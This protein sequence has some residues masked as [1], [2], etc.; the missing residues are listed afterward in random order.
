MMLSLPKGTGEKRGTGD[1]RVFQSFGV[2]GQGP[3]LGWVQNLR[4]QRQT[5]TQ[6]CGKQNQSPGPGRVGAGSSP[7]ATCPRQCSLPGFAAD[8]P[9]A[10]PTP[11]KNRQCACAP[12]HTLHTDLGRVEGPRPQDVT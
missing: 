11:R 6:G 3:G 8:V 5:P 2:D 12:A 10:Q 1:L 7:A 4:V 9:T